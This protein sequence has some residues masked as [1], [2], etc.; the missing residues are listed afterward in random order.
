M[1]CCNQGNQVRRAPTPVGVP[2]TPRLPPI[3]VIRSA[4]RPVVTPRDNSSGVDRH[5]QGGKY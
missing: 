4:P 2:M 1:G 5:R 3:V